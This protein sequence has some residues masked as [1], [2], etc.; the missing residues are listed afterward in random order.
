MDNRANTNHN[1]LHSLIKNQSVKI[2]EH[3]KKIEEL[4]RRMDEITAKQA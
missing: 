2:S 1:Q 4:N 3:A